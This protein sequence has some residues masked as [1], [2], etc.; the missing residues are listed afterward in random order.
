VIGAEHPGSGAGGR[1]FRVGAAFVELADTPFNEQEVSGYLDVLCRRTVDLVGGGEVGVLL[2]NSQGTLSLM[3]SS[4]ERMHMLEL[5]QLQGTEGPC[6]E[7][8][9]SG[10]PV[11]NAP[12]AASGDRWPT[13]TPLALGVGFR[14]VSSIPMRVQAQTI[15]AVNVFSTSSTGL[16][17]SGYRLGE[18]LAHVATI[19][20]FHQR[21]L[22]QAQGLAT[23][24]Q[25][26]LDSR[27]VIEQAKGMVAE[28]MGIRVEDAFLLIRGHARVQR[29][30]LAAVAA[31]VVSGVLQPTELGAS[32]R[33]PR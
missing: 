8:F 4:T 5:L 3:A 23:Q 25:G 29:A 9:H 16:D 24:L 21:A 28:R 32:R 7:S 14:S 13:F 22:D 15:G 11:V 12:L 1:E 27:V 30:P 6:F 2:A 20:I 31:A 19:G 18:A 17:A 33:P 26:A 10:L